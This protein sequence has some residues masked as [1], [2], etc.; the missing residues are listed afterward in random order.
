MLRTHGMFFQALRQRVGVQHAL[1]G[2]HARQLQPH[3]LDHGKLHALRF[4]LLRCELL[5]HRFHIVF[6][7]GHG[8]C[9]FKG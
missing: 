1:R 6:A 4:E 3:L 8:P 7:R 9:P 2:Q 5:A